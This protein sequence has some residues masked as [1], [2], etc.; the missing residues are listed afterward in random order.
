MIRRHGDAP[1]RGQR[2][3]HRPGVYAILPRGKDILLTFQQ[4]PVPEPQLPG[5]GVD[6]GEHPLAALH[7]EVME[8]TGWT[9][10][11]PRHLGAFR[12]FVWMP[13][14]GIHAEKVCHVY[15]AHPVRRIGEPSEP[16]HTAFWSP[17]E[18]APALLTN[19]GDSAFVRAL[20]AFRAA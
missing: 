16:G 11:R 15:L 7:R 9:I 17:A 5:G 18:D 20:L 10:A 1:L 6:A 8:E 3:I 14:Y 2:Y 13:D 4:D 12:R 19:E